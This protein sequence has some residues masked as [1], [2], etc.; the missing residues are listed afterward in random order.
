MLSVSF[1]VVSVYP[2]ITLDHGIRAVRRKLLD[3]DSESPSVELMQLRLSERVPT[4]NLNVDII[5][6]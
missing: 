1:Y 5:S 4:N 3:R 2:N 6:H